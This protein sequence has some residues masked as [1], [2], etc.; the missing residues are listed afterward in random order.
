MCIIIKNLL[1][2]QIRLDF[3]DFSF[4]QPD[5][6]GTCDYDLFLITGASSSVPR[7]CGENS[8]QH[9]ITIKNNLKL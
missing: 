5:K 9:G 4:A 2:L 7:L 6:N 8:N 3:I 1:C